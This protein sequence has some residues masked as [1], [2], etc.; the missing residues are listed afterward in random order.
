MRWV[1]CAEEA[2][3]VET[4]VALTMN[5][6]AIAAIAASQSGSVA[7]D[8]ESI[9]TGLSNSLDLSEQKLWRC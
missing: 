5:V 1:L 6:K 8:S 7:L 9:E 3:C 2:F 4:G